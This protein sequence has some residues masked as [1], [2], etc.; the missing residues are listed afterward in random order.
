MAAVTINGTDQSDLIDDNFVDTDG[1]SVSLYDDNLIIAGKG[2]DTIYG[3]YYDDTIYGV[4]GNN[5]IDSGFG[6]D[7]VNTGRHSSTVDA[8]YG[9]DTVIADLSKGADH[10]I[11]LGNYD[12]DRDVIKLENISYDRASHITVREFMPNGYYDGDFADELFIEGEIVGFQNLPATMSLSENE[13]GDAVLSFGDDDTVTFVGTSL[14]TLL[15]IYQDGTIAGTDG[16]DYFDRSFVDTD[17]EKLSDVYFVELL[18]GDDY[19][20]VFDMNADIDLGEGADTLNYV[21]EIGTPDSNVNL[22]DLSAEDTLLLNGETI[23]WS[24][25]AEGNLSYTEFDGGFCF[26]TDNNG[27]INVFGI[28]LGEFLGEP[29]VVGQVDGTNRDDMIITGYSDGD[30]EAVGDGDDLVYAG[31]GN[32]EVKGYQ[33]S[34]TIYGGDGNDRL[35][36]DRGNDQL[37]GESGDDTLGSGTSGSFLS[38]GEGNDLLIA[39][40]NKGGDHTLSGGAD[41]DTFDLRYADADKISDITITDFEVGF[42]T[43][44]IDEQEIDLSALPNGATLA[45]NDAGQAVLTLETGDSV[46]FENQSTNNL[47]GIIE[48]NGSVDGTSGAD[49]INSGFADVEGESVS[50]GADLVYAGDGSDTVYG[51]R[52][53][54]TIYGGTGQDEIYGKTGSNALYGQSGD[55]TLSSGR[56]TSFLDGGSG[57]DRLIAELNAGAD[58]TLVGGGGYDTFVMQSVSSTKSSTVVIDDF[59]PTQDTLLIGDMLVDLA[60]LPSDVR[61]SEDEDGNVVVHFNDDDT[62][63]LNAVGLEDLGYAPPEPT[64]IGVIDGTSGNDVID[65]T[66]VDADGEAQTDG[67]DLIK[68][69]AGDDQIISDRGGD[70]I[71]GGSGMDFIKSLRGSKELYGDDGTDVLVAMRHTSVL[72]GG[73]DVDILAGDLSKGADHVMTG[74]TGND[75]F[76]LANVSDEKTSNVTITDFEGASEALFIENQYI[77]FSELNADMSLSDDEDGNAVLHFGDDDTVTFTGQSS[78]DL[79]ADDIMNDLFIEMTDEELE[80]AANETLDILFS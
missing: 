70:T 15:D 39:Q 25:L 1:D 77:S 43:L 11:S 22:F 61:L 19:I 68:A 53:A 38:G 73:D 55:D 58:H 12:Y 72:D 56:H 74:G 14:S 18:S 40:M 45:D 13:D 37:F 75:L 47:L 32:D 20:E 10:E 49:L 52:G 48:P 26:Y 21:T 35:F 76:W 9:H 62:I 36:G 46:I 8:G 24:M 51:Y 79:I 59:D 29:S 4:S 63:T 69:G 30:G 31:A 57:D 54:D 41:S 64:E 17:L 16:D 28:S 71:F 60:N 34:D 33:G 65:G 23:S 27:A 3:G 42:D 2:G 5:L 50:D 67:G 66:Y 6:D 44:V 80:A 7:L 78:A